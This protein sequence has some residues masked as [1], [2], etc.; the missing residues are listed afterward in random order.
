M[1][2][3][4]ASTEFKVSICEIHVNSFL[5]KNLEE[6]MT[7]LKIYV[8]NYICERLLREL[9]L[10]TPSAERQKIVGFTF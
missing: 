6:I 4:G 3:T 1:K 7:L 5:E 10:T 2:E 8:W 9:K